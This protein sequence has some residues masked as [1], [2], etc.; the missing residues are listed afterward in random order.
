MHLHSFTIERLAIELGAKGK[1]HNLIGKRLLE[2]F[3]TDIE[4]IVLRFENT[5]IKV[6][7][8][9][10]EGLFQFPDELKL[11]KKNRLASFKE[12]TGEGIWVEDVITYPFDRL[13]EIKF[14]Q[15]YSLYFLLFGRFSQIGLYQ[16]KKLIS[17]FP[18][19]AKD[20]EVI[21]YNSQTTEA[22]CDAVDNAEP[23]NHQLK[24]LNQTQK[25]E[26]EKL[27]FLQSSKE[28]QIRL[29]NDLKTHYLESKIYISKG[30]KAYQLKY[31]SSEDDLSSFDNIA[32]AL[33][34]F[35]RLYISHKVFNDTKSSHL[36]VLKKELKTLK[37]KEK[38]LNKKLGSLSHASSYKQKADLLMAYLHLVPANASSVVLDN[39]EGTEKI[40]IALNKTLTPQANAERFYRKSKNESKQVD[41]VHK[42][43]KELTVKIEQKES[44]IK[45]FSELESFKDIVKTTQAKPSKTDIRLPY[46]KLM[47]DG[48]EIRVGRGAKDNDELLR[49]YTSKNDIWLHAKSV[50]G[51]HV[52]IRNPSKK[53]VNLTT[54]EKAAQLAAFYSKAKTESLAAVMYTERKFVRKP[55]GA[56]PGLVKVDKED[57]ILV[58][59]KNY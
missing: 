4:S 1:S 36:G 49:S 26:L 57:T 23:L 30:E 28:D 39:F 55:K 46:R 41:F 25:Q 52:I 3:S 50:S 18:A 10:G 38:S 12:L 20:V 32:E 33:D 24:F 56:T 47:I 37:T 15:G 13:F 43:L 7:F 53:E 17:H 22:I 42:N 44:E 34:N 29:L 48:Y 6:S 5:T 11:Q 59:P 54:I 14:N 9:K 16:D 31:S 2:A 45:V 58:E 51:S 27:T 35:T 8:F 19:K 40:S 21:D